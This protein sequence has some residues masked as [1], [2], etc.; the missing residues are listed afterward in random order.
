MANITRAASIGDKQ[1]LRIIWKTAFG[2]SDEEI[3]DFFSFY[4]APQVAIV[5]DNGSDPIAAGYLLPVGNL[6]CGG[7]KVPCAMIYAVATLPEYRNHGYGSAVVRGLIS[8]GYAKGCKAVVLCPSDNDLFEYYSARTDL[9]DWFHVSQRKVA[10]T[11]NKE[12]RPSAHISPPVHWPLSPLPLGSSHPLKLTP[13]KA[14]EYNCLREELLLEVPHIEFDLRALSYQSLLSN[15]SGGGL[16]RIDGHSGVGCAVVEKQ[17]GGAVWI[18]ELLTSHI[19]ETDALSSVALMYPADEY[20]VR[21]PS[22]SPTADS[23]TL[24]FGMLAS[25]D[26][27]ILRA[28]SEFHD[29]AAPYYGLAFD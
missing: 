28:S 11:K 24:R 21:S 7:M 17:P 2:D 20:L 14:N 15:H 1:A 16:F 13:I 27:R 8:A 6:L 22:P 5:V 9:H 18:K 19:N 12:Y 10:L 23:K 4:F 25:S 29:S 3:D 26:D